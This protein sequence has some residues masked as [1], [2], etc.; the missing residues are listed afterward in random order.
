MKQIVG[1]CTRAISQSSG[2][3]L[4]RACA[5]GIFMMPFEGG[6]GGYVTGFAPDTGSPVSEAASS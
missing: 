6:F 5:L 2:E 1:K 4:S 3:I